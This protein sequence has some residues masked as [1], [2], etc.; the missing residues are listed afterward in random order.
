MREQTSALAPMGATTTAIVHRLS[1]KRQ[2]IAGSSRELRR[3]SSENSAEGGD[4]QRHCDNNVR[5]GGGGEAANGG[6]GDI[7]SDKE[8]GGF[9][10]IMLCAAALARRV[11]NVLVVAELPSAAPAGRFARVGR[12]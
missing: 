12:Q 6:Q 7:D 8:E 1:P 3:K 2:R 10:C 11:S 9:N 5:T 4:H